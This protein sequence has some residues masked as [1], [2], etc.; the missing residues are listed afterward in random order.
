VWLAE[1]E[2]RRGWATRSLSAFNLGAQSAPTEFLIHPF[3]KNCAF[4]ALVYQ[5]GLFYGRRG[6]NGR[7]RCSISPGAHGRLAPLLTSVRVRVMHTSTSP[8][9]VPEEGSRDKWSSSAP[10]S[11]VTPPDETAQLESLEQEAVELLLRIMRN[12]EKLHAGI[13]GITSAST[14][15]E[16]R[17]GLQSSRATRCNTSSQSGSAC[18][19]T[20]SSGHS[21]DWH[22]AGAGADER[23]HRR[24]V[25]YSVGEA[26]PSALPQGRGDTLG[27]VE[28]AVGC[29][30]GSAEWQRQVAEWSDGS[31][32]R[33]SWGGQA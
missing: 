20:S 23:L 33:T 17:E 10:S 1:A 25:G 28:G 31:Q 11:R 3:E 15:H 26:I 5:S 9:A 19:R 4:S 7:H 32:G 21:L 6:Q 18:G 13:S 24:M 22:A 2:N 8:A 12:S 16:I 27:V 30:A 14:L 29:Q